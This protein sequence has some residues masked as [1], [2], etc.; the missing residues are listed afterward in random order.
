MSPLRHSTNVAARMGRWSARHRKTAIF[1]WLAFVIASF[2]VGMTVG[3]RTIDESDYT[4]GEARQG[5][6]IIRDG[7]FSVDE[8]AEFVLVES[9]TRTADDPRLPCRR[10]RRGCGPR[11]VPRGREA[12]IAVRRRQ[13]GPDLQGRPRRA[14]P[15][16]P[17][18]DVRRGRRVH[19]LVFG[20]LVGASVPLLLAL[21]SVFATMGLVALPSLVVPMDESISEVILLIAS[22]SV[23]T[24]HCS[25]SAASVTSGGRDAARRRRWRPRRQRRDARCSSPGSR[26]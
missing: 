4:V 18:G 25:T 2:V 21:T 23:S 3:L 24:T 16:Q 22:R 5:D 17:H 11:P 20:S 14:D 19:L 8:Q 12:S 13:R 10:E 1:G 7:G 6:H 15:V 26:S 9:R